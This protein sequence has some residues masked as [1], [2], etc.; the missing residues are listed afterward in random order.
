M[1]YDKRT[2]NIHTMEGEPVFGTGL[3]KLLAYDD[4]AMMGHFLMPKGTVLPVHQH[5]HTQIG[6]VLEGKMEFTIGEGS[7]AEKLTVTSGSGYIF[8]SME[9]HSAVA[10]E[11]CIIVE[12]FTPIREDFITK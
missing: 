5:E 12:V 1:K 6:Y 7:K 2:S 3:R 9:V 8:H 4:H 10:I 11:D